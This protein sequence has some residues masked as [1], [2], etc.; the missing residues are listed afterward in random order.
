MP[1][2]TVLDLPT[3]PLVRVFFS[4][5]TISKPAADAK[6]CEVFI[7]RVAL[8]HVPS[9]EVRIK[10]PGQRDII[11][12]RQ[13]APFEFA[14]PVPPN[15]VAEHS[16]LITTAAARGIRGYEGSPTAEGQT[17]RKA[18]D[19]NVLHPG[20]TNVHKP[21]GQPSIFFND[22]VFY[23][24]DITDPGL[25]VELRRVGSS[26]GD[27]LPPFASLIGANIYDTRVTLEWRQSGA[28]QTLPLTELPAGFSYEIYVIN[29]P[30][31]EPLPPAGTQPHDELEEYYKL[32]RD[33]PFP[34][35]FRFFFRKI[36]D[37]LTEKTGNRGSSRTPCMSV[38]SNG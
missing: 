34:E 24:A 22:A 9:I 30:P 38:I 33:V 7:H 25:E 6:T 28:L 12:M 21:S 29:D 18:L 5:L 17:L 16:L 10:R 11:L 32:L 26:T 31:F 14:R 19:L 23:S 35:Q 1:F 3:N 2:S 37:A 36:P 15:P 27:L 4:G 20:K 8:N 13:V